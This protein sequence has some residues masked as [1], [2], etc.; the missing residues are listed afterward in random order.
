MATI[1]NL[2]KLDIKCIKRQVKLAF[3][4]RNFSQ[5]NSR[6]VAQVNNGCVINQTHWV[7]IL[8][9]FLGYNIPS[10]NFQASNTSNK[11]IET[12]KQASGGILSIPFIKAPSIKPASQPTRGCF[13][14]GASALSREAIPLK[15]GQTVT[16]TQMIQAMLKYIWPKDDKS[17]RDR[18]KVALSLLV[19]A[20]L[21]NVTV[22]FIFK[23]SVDYLNAG[24]SLN[25]ETAP[26]T[27]T[28]VLTSLL[29]GC[30]YIRKY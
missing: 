7:R 23:Y 19:C 26:E 24:G 11:E 10:I 3:I 6:K 17:V 29:L 30:K 20:K 21:L 15:D 12:K 8:R 9:N 22:P 13:H 4:Y 14:P 1:V 16:G 18:V 25:M 28:T 5:F 27:I 2:R